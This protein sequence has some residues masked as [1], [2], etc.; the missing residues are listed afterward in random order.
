MLS[1]HGN[2]KDDLELA[3]TIAEKLKESDQ[4]VFLDTIGWVYYKLGDS[5]KAIVYLDQVV[6]KM[7]EVNVFNF[8]LG[9]AYKLSGDKTQ[10]KIYLEK[11]L[12]DKKEFKQKELAEAA[13]KEL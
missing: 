4:P 6:E 12:A 8:H 9:M 11:S 1:D 3:K 5:A 2:G 10:A 13:L 7:P